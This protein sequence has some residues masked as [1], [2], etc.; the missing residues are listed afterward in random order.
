MKKMTFGTMILAAALMVSSCSKQADKKAQNNTAQTETTKQKDYDES[1]EDTN[2]SASKETAGDTT[3]SD[4]KIKKPQPKPSLGPGFTI[5][6]KDD[7]YRIYTEADT[8]AFMRDEYF[9]MCFE[10][11]A[12]DGTTFT[13]DV[14]TGAVEGEYVKIL[15][16]K[17][18]DGVIKTDMEK[19]R[20][21]G[22]ISE[23]TRIDSHTLKVEF[24]VL[25][26]ET[27][28]DYEYTY[29]ENGKQREDHVT[30]ANP[31][32]LTEIDNMYIY[33]PNTRV[34]DLPSA[35][36]NEYYKYGG[37]MGEV[38]TNAFIFYNETENEFF[39]TLEGKIFDT[40]AP[41]EKEMMNWYGN[42][43]LL[44]GTM[45]IYYD[46]NED[47]VKAVYIPE[48]SGVEYHLYVERYED[49]ENYLLFFG[50]ADNGEALV[51]DVY[52]TGS[53]I[54]DVT[55]QAVTDPFVWDMGRTSIMI[56]SF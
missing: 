8:L 45:D 31:K 24:C 22:G 52:D 15:D 6:C 44:N 29:K 32:G 23:L 10:S 12:C 25:N 37:V 4:I 36:V 41:D 7:I 16:Q 55:V 18:E 30:F 40:Y 33:L 27:F 54:Y 53:G 14:A 5:D 13:Y 38:Y 50:C 11:L 35:L 43:A 21:S 3:E 17:E 51:F 56:K 20:F 49:D 34:S 2:K 19:C 42:Y 26:T 9:Y 48:V 28:E 47:A 1:E 46:K 39:M